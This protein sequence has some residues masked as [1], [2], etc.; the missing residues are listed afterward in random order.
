MPIYN[1]ILLTIKKTAAHFRKQQM[2][3]PNILTTQWNAVNDNDDNMITAVSN[4][5]HQNNKIILYK[6]LI[7]PVLCHKV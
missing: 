6:T 2:I 1:V 5:T 4:R 7:K 3:L